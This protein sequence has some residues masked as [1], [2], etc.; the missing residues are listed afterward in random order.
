MRRECAPPWWPAN[1]PWPPIR[2]RGP[3]KS[4]RAAFVFILVFFFLATGASSLLTFALRGIVGPEYMRYAVPLF[5]W[6]VL[7]SLFVFGFRRVGAPVA[8]IVGAAQRVADGDFST[9]VDPDGPRFVRT[10][11][12][13]FNRMTE[14]LQAHDRQRRELMADIAHELRTPLTVIQGRLEGLVD[15]VYPRDTERL[16]AVLDET[17][18]LARLV[19]DLR[20]LANAETGILTLR[21]ER[22]ELHPLI[23]DAVGTLSAEAASAGVTVDVEIPP[24]LPPLDIDPLRVREVVVNLL[25]NAL[26]YSAPGGTVTISTQRTGSAVTVA[27]SDTGAG[28]PPEDLPRIFERFYKGRASRG[29][30]LGL[31]IARNLISAHGG[32]IHAEST[33]GRG[34]TIR[35]TLS[36]VAPPA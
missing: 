1:E 29:S 36:Y 9:R 12:S 18:V 5:A 35:F 30:G 20:T 2:R 3:F 11:A 21:K 15:G 31:T 34:T 23:H 16:A 13:A 33:P 28:I 10:V 19:E 24:D 14:R 6:M 7:F 27:V 4:W 26:R 32:T 22:T 17:R 25:S 8:Q